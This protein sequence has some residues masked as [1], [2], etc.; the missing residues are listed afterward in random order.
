MKTTQLQAQLTRLSGNASSQT[1][2]IATAVLE[3]GKH[4]W[5]W[6]I[7]ICPYC[8]KQHDHYG[9][10]LDGNPQIY[11]GLTFPA[12]CDNTDR[13]R[14][15]LGNPDTALFYVLTNDLPT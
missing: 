10:A 12:H 4:S 1:N 3:R 14:L 5:I 8:G 6:V 15:S 7:P 9:G 13:Q 11:V 2:C